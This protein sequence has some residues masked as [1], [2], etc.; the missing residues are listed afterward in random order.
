MNASETILHT[1]LEEVKIVNLLQFFLVLQVC[2][3]WFTDTEE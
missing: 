3:D 1:V 2:H